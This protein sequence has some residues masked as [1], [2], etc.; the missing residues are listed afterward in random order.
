MCRWLAY[1]GSPPLL[2]EALYGPANSLIEQSLHS[3]LGAETTNGDEVSEDSH[4]VVSEPLGDMPGVWNEVPKAT[5]RIVG[6]G[7]DEQ[8]PFRRWRHELKGDAGASVCH[9]PPEPRR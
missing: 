1:S 4:M 3:R 5:C 8:S 7:H 9:R 2:K 6:Q